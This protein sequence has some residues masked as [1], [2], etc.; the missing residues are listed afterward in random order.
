M[1]VTYEHMMA[2]KRKTILDI[3]DFLGIDDIPAIPDAILNK[4]YA[5]FHDGRVGRG[6]IILSEEKRQK[7]KRLFSYYE[8]IDFSYY[9]I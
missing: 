9:G 3:L 5:N 1:W 2:N 4:K 6:S 7:V 8:D